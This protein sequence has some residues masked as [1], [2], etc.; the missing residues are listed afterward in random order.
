MFKSVSIR[1]KTSVS[2]S[3]ISLGGSNNFRSSVAVRKYSETAKLKSFDISA[4]SI[5]GKT[6]I[7]GKKVGFTVE[8]ATVSPLEA[9]VG[10]LA[11]CENATAMYHAKVMNFK[12]DKLEF[13]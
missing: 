4:V 8:D 11:A 13:N 9:T 7:Q 10:S 12:Y 5:G 3:K 2:S 1:P 6:E